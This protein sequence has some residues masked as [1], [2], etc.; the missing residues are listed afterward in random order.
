M[1]IA[2]IALVS[3]FNGIMGWIANF[4]FRSLFSFE[5]DAT[6]SIQSVWSFNAYFDTKMTFELILGKMFTPLAFLGYS[7]G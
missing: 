6:E 2:F 1:L 7:M 3:L 5:N 4:N